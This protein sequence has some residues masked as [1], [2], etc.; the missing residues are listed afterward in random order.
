MLKYV[1]KTKINID[2]FY[3]NSQN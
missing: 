2:K 1:N 3:K